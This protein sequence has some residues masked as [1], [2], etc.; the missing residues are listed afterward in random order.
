[1]ANALKIAI[2]GAGRMGGAHIINL[3]KGRVKGAC[4]SAVCDIDESVLGK[5]KN[6]FPVFNTYEEL[7]KDG[8]FDAALIATPH[9]FHVPIASALINAGK[10]VYI[11]KPVAVT[12]KAAK[13]LNALI[14]EKDAVC[15]V[16]YNQRTNPTYI[17]A[18]DIIES[19]RLGALKRANFIVT[20]WYRSDAYYKQNPWRGS[21]TGEGGGVLINQCVHQLDILSWLIGMPQSVYAHIATK[22]RMIT[23][24]NAVTAL[25]DYGNGVFCTISASGHELHGTNLIE[26]AGEKGKLT[27]TRSKAKFVEF[28]KAEPEINAETT[29]GYGSCAKKTHTKY[30]GVAQ[31]R[32]SLYG[33]QLLSFQNFVNRILYGEKLSAPAEEGINAL[34][35]INSIYLSAWKNKE[36]ILPFDD[37]EYE[38]YLN[39]KIKEE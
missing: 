26:I 30:Y 39:N 14:A 21:Y 20:D 9:Y 6:K 24:E 7:I 38:N 18:K 34:T 28:E 13:E 22:G 11:E 27:L 37:T 16:G 5:Y 23:A 4:L 17:F 33:Q 35:L 29:D 2:I 31:I 10:A 8:N 3:I 36:I 32:D 19:G 25:L 12:T 1:M 15:A